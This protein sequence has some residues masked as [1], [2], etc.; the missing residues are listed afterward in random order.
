MSVIDT[1]IHISIRMFVQ[2]SVI[3]TLHIDFFDNLFYPF[4]LN[5]HH[6]FMIKF[7]TTSAINLIENWGRPYK[8]SVSYE[9]F[10]KV[11]QV[12]HHVK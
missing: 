12:G 2:V 11:R 5:L 9:I 7:N 1:Y 3:N 8:K 10:F 4:P 6:K